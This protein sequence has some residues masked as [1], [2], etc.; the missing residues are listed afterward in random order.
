[1]EVINN[2]SSLPPYKSLRIQ[3]DVDPL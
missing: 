3:I 2:I 1:M